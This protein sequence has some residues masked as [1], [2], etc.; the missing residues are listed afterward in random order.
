[1]PR[2]R[3]GG[4]VPGTPAFAGDADRR[5]GEEATDSIMA[6]HLPVA[7]APITGTAQTAAAPWLAKPQL[8]PAD[9]VP[10]ESVG[11]Y[12]LLRRYGVDAPRRNGSPASTSRWPVR[13]G[14]PGSG[15]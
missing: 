15:R 3:D 8:K 7:P 4:L 9:C 11:A 14:T 5:A 10:E 1:M 6:L 13:S 12:T 2:H